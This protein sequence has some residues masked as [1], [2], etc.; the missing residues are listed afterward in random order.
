VQWGHTSTVYRLEESPSLRRE[1]LSNIVTEFTVTMK[2]TRIIKRYLNGTYNQVY[3]GK[4]LFGAFS[5]LNSLKGVT[6]SPL[7]S[8]SL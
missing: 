6:L 5:V 3:V 2:L 7:F 1:L 8:T 4:C